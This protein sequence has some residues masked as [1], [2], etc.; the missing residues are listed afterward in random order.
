MKFLDLSHT[1]TLQIFMLLFKKKG[2]LTCAISHM[3]KQLKVTVLLKN[4]NYLLK[5]Y[6]FN[7]KCTSSNVKLLQI[8]T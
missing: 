2:Y 8:Y 3:L 7:T 4:N 5:S 1:R 6:I